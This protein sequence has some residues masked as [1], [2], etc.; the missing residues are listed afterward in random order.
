MQC[1]IKSYSPIRWDRLPDPT[2]PETGYVSVELAEHHWRKIVQKHFGGSRRDEPWKDVID[3]DDL[4][5]LCKTPFGPWHKNESAG[6]SAMSVLAVLEREVRCSLE[7]PLAM[8]YTSLDGIAGKLSHRW[9]LLLPSGAVAGILLNRNTLSLKTCYFTGVVAV[10]KDRRKRWQRAVQQTVENNLQYDK[11]LDAF[12]LP[13]PRH[14]TI[15]NTQ[16]RFIF[17]FVTPAQ[18]GFASDAVGSAWVKS[19]I[20]A[21]WNSDHKSS[22]KLIPPGGADWV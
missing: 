7:R 2:H 16:M 8:I 9:L 22:T 11:D 20:S 5:Q 17:R 18:W 13:G 21:N 19:K 4:A 15:T 14:R 6:K 12:V 1:A 3:A 10:V